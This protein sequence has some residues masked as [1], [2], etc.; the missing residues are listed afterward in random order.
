[1]YRRS[2]NVLVVDDDTVALCQTVAL[3]KQRDYIVFAA[4][5]IQHAQWWLSQ[6]AVDLLIAPYTLH[7]M[8]GLHLLAAARHLQPAL[9]AILVGKERSQLTD[10]DA[11]QHRVSLILQP[12]DPGLFLMLVAE[13]L[14]AVRQRQ[15]W[16]RKPV[17]FNMPVWVAGAPAWLIDVSYGGL[18]F[19]L[20]GESFDLPS[21][22]TIDLPDA[23][24]QVKAQLVW[25][26]RAS[27]GVRCTCGVA[28][29]DDEPATDWR[30]FVDCVPQMS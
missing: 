21:P 6:R 17:Q 13:T 7:G 4:H 9:A 23:R 14:A 19:A 25:S 16:P 18:R 26:S 28:I 24:L 20:Q 10:T 11:A 22:M 5:G 1:M 8:S 15:R 27:D 30:R 29:A 3:L 2:S 12:Y